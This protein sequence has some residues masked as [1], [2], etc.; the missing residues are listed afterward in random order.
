MLK[1]ILAQFQQAAAPLCV[2]E[3]SRKLDI[4]AGALEGMLYTLVQRGRLQQIDPQPSGCTTCPA[5]GGCVILTS[6]VQK[7]Y[8]LPPGSPKR[9]PVTLVKE[10]SP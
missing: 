5:R 2:D 10:R 8:V 7:S 1:E 6:G 4:E 3:L 9:P